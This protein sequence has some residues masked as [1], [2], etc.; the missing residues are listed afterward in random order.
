[1][2]D[3]YEKLKGRLKN[4]SKVIIMGIGEEKL[5]DDGVGPYIIGELL[6]HFNLVNPLNDKFLLINAGTDPMARVDEI[7][8]FKPSHLILIDTCTL[9]KPPG[10]L[11]I[12]EREDIREYVPIS[13]HTIPVHIVMDLILEQVP[14]LDLFMIGLVP[15]SLEGF[16][17][18]QF[19]KGDRIDEIDK[20]IDLPFFKINLTKK[21][22]KVALEIIK[23]IR[24][25]IIEPL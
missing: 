20:N 24:K 7:I 2:N 1:M 18:L 9:D 4:A 10:T 12:L 5:R 23:I 11:V 15:E 14:M 13:S 21:I 6:T 17:N 16:E 8:K 22:E 25:L 19:Y 3:L